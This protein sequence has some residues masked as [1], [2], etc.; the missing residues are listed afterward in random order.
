MILVCCSFSALEGC[1]FLLESDLSSSLSGGI[2]ITVKFSRI[3]GETKTSKGK[4]EDGCSLAAVE[5]VT[6]F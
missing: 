6:Y 3:E 1:D 2:V 4:E 5:A